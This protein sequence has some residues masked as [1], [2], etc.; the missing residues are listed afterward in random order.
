MPND[1]FVD[2]DIA[3]S[4]A[5]LYERVTR[6]LADNGH[7]VAALLQR[8]EEI[9]RFRILFSTASRPEKFA[10]IDRLLSAAMP[11]HEALLARLLNEEGSSE[12]NS[13]QAELCDLHRRALLCRMFSNRRLEMLKT[14]SAQAAN[15]DERRIS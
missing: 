11:G 3:P 4:A 15:T 1:L 7:S 10:F 5:H 9:Q 6:M 8:P 13:F 12:S 2:D 14:C